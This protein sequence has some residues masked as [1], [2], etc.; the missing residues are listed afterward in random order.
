MRKDIYKEFDKEINESNVDIQKIEYKNKVLNE[1]KFESKMLF[2]L[3]C[4]LLPYIVT[5]LGAIRLAN[6]SI[7]PN[8][9]VPFLSV[10]L[11]LVIGISSL[12]VFNKKTNIKDKMNQF[13]SAKNYKEL[14]EEEI[15]N[16]IEKQKLISFKRISNDVKK[17]SYFYDEN[18]GT[19]LMDDPRSEEEI[20]ES[21]EEVEKLLEENKKELDISITQNVLK[22][23][24]I[25]TRDRWQKFMKVAIYGGIGG[26]LACFLLVVPCLG[27]T[28]LNIGTLGFFSTL[29]V[30]AATGT[31]FAL[32]REHDYKTVFNKINSSLGKNAIT[33]K[34]NFENDLGYVKNM[35]NLLRNRFM[36]RLR[37]EKDKIKL[38]DK[39]NGSFKRVN[40]MRN[41]NSISKN[42]I[43][44]D[45]N[46]KKKSS[47]K[48]R[49]R[50]LDNK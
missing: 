17:N 9:L 4:S 18:V 22:D 28:G 32:K 19:S 12:N 29:S 36:M 50:K 23:R 45:V 35:E 15:L 37:F 25:T 48:V 24:F 10:A 20:S 26:I 49:V 39:R 7:I 11:P 2:V 33:L 30:G 47:S 31:L 42:N 14:L 21:I 43:Y 34:S 41:S 27:V 1:N 40:S 6:A 44:E 8:E 16:E 46:N 13:S 5:C 38:N 3:F